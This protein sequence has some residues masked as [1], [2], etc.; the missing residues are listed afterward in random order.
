[1]VKIASRFWKT[2]LALGLLLIAMI[3]AFMAVLTQPKMAVV[4]FTFD[5][6]SNSQYNIAFQTMQEAGLSGTL[7][8]PTEMV[9]TGKNNVLDVW[10]MSWDSIRE[11]HNNGWEIGSHSQ[12]HRRLT[13]LSTEEVNAELIGSLLEIEKQTGARPVSFSSPFGNFNDDVLL[14]IMESYAY[15]LSWKGHGGRVPATGFENRYIGRLEVTNSMTSVQVCG[16]MAEAAR[17]DVWLILLFH[18]IV[19]GEAGE[20]EVSASV[21]SEIIACAHYLDSQGVIR[22]ETVKDAVKALEWRQNLSSLNGL[23]WNN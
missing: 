19:E 8:V 2:S 17:N 16:E 13:E 3:I 6:A 15:H 5:D 7:F 18:T 20:Y 14:R 23:H 10:T 1:M 12:T 11:M 9:N 21:F 4:S 22:V